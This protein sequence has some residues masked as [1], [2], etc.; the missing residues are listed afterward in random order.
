MSNNVKILIIKNLSGQRLGKVAFWLEKNE[1]DLD[2]SCHLEKEK[3]ERLLKKYFDH[4]LKNFG[5]VVF[6][7]PIKSNNPIFLEAINY[8]LAKNGYVSYFE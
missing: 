7:E 3:I 4:G 5:P 2:I 1:F 6:H 8:H